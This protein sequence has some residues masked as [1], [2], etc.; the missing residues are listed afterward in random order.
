M[1]DFD[2]VMPDLEKM[3]TFPAS[4]PLPDL[5]GDLEFLDFF[6][7]FLGMQPKQVEAFSLAPLNMDG[8]SPLENFSSSSQTSVQDYGFQQLLDCPSST[9]PLLDLSSLE[10]TAP[11]VPGL[12]YV[13]HTEPTAL[14]IESER[15]TTPKLAQT[16][17]SRPPALVVTEQTRANLLKDLS[18]RLPP[19][20]AFRLPTATA[21][22][23]C[24]R[25]YVD[26][27]HVHL[28]I[29]HLHTMDLAQTPSPLVLAICAIGAQYRLER[30]VAAALYVKADQ[31][32]AAVTDR[33]DRLHQIPR[34][35]E[36]WSRP[37][38][39]SEERT[40]PGR[41]SLWTSQ[42]RLLLAM[43][44]SFS[45]DLEV[46]F[47]ALVHLGDFLIVSDLFRLT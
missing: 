23:K 4:V 33:G 37:S 47:K 27:F 7:P 11:A 39:A 46:I 19:D 21:L 9:S 28:P 36:D 41:I 35:L 38:A 16:L 5:D 12:N 13:D 20:P 34:L 31:A 2:A 22:Q 26:A 15:S 32:L 42:T 45:G 43:F 18:S 30:K 17:S 10:T 29:F 24:V 44:A 14:L 8:W 40:K 6:D 25:T 3:R 1:P